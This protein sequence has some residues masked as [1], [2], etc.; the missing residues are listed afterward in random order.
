MKNR[1]GPNFGNTT[2]NI[3]YNTLT[4]TD[5]FDSETVQGTTDINSAMSTL[6]MLSDG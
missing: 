6:S 1:F 5:D 2:L 3:D 4:I